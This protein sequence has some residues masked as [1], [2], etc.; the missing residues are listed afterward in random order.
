MSRT[1]L[2]TA[3]RDAVAKRLTAHPELL[4]AGATVVARERGKLVPEIQQTIARLKLGVVVL[5]CEISRV[6]PNSAPPLVEELR[7]SVA[8]SESKLND[9]AEG[10][11]VAELLLVLLHTL[12]LPEVG[13]EVTLYAD[14]SPLRYDETTHGLAV[15]TISFRCTGL[16]AQ[17]AVQAP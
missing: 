14:E 3:V 9:G 11:E 2:T 4:A 1:F 15:S 5:P 6:N 8:V 7:V 13:P 17:R 12:A 10:E 16:P